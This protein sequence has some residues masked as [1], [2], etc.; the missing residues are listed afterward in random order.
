MRVDLLETTWVRLNI[1]L[2][3]FETRMKKGNVSETLKLK[4]KKVDLIL[5]VD[6]ILRYLRYC[7][8]NSYSRIASPEFPDCI[9][10]ASLYWLDF[11]FV[12]T[13]HIPN[14]VKSV[15]SSW[16]SCY[17]LVHKHNYEKSPFL[18]G[19][20]TINGHSQ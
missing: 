16:F 20:S 14:S 18:M 1:L 6:N 2:Q 8:A 13:Y 7:F 11:V 19:K 15:K 9:T 5:I 12:S 10:I 3:I 4:S 17:T